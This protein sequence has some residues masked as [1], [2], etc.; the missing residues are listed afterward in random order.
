SRNRHDA[1][2]VRLPNFCA[3]AEA[4]NLHAL[5]VGQSLQLVPRHGGTPFVGVNAAE[6]V[7]V[8][9]LER[10]ASDVQEFRLVPEIVVMV[11]LPEGEGDTP[12]PERERDL[13]PP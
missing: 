9:L 4:A 5:E 12:G 1:G 3:E 13:A 10:L 11:E 6:E 7:H 8:E 2:A